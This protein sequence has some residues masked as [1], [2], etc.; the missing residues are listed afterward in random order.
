MDVEEDADNSQGD[1]RYVDVRMRFTFEEDPE[2]AAWILAQGRKKSFAFLSIVQV[3]RKADLLKPTISETLFALGQTLALPV[4][5]WEQRGHSSAEL[6]TLPLRV[7][8]EAR[9]PGEEQSQRQLRP[10]GNQPV[11][12]QTS[13]FLLDEIARS[14]VRP[15]A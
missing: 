14:Y 13:A 11:D 2:I 15:L 10:D 6:Q 4:Q 3:L 5:Q 9:R 12:E 8:E 1:V 7:V